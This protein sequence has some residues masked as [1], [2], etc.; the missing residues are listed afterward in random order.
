LLRARGGVETFFCGVERRGGEGGSSKNS[1]AFVAR[2]GRSREEG[3]AVVIRRALWG[4]GDLRALSEPERGLAGGVLEDFGDG[5]F[6]LL[7]SA[8][9]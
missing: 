7:S 4:A 2:L 6:R 5:R 3:P 8:I 9:S 1:M